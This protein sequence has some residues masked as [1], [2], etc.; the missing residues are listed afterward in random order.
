MCIHPSFCSKLDQKSQGK[1]LLMNRS[2][3]HA[4]QGLAEV[5]TDIL[6]AKESAASLGT[7][8]VVYYQ[9]PWVVTKRLCN[10]V[11]SSD[12]DT[13]RDNRITAVGKP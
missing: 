12:K 9:W 8:V 4:G 10:Y 5:S 11:S 7:A 3:V 1:F 6:I 13:I 2:G